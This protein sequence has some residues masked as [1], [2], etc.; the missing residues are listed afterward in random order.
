MYF[1]HGELQNNLHYNMLDIQSQLLVAGPVEFFSMYPSQS[2]CLKCK[3]KCHFPLDIPL[4]PRPYNWFVS[5]LPKKSRSE[6]IDVL[7][8]YCPRCERFSLWKRKTQ[9]VSAMFKPSKLYY[10]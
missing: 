7:E 8:V 10:N 5:Y 3:A 2:R 6:R 4:Q 1:S 9:G